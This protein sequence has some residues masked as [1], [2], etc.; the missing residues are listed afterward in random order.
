[1]T[2]TAEPVRSPRGYPIILRK[3]LQISALLIPTSGETNMSAAITALENAYT[4][5][6]LTANGIALYHT[7]GNTPTPHALPTANLLGFIRVIQK[8]FPNRDEVYANS[9]RFSVTVEADY[10]NDWP[11]LLVFS[12]TIQ[13]IGTGGP[14]FL[15]VDL[16]QGLPDEQITATNT[17]CRATQS[18]IAVQTSS[19]LIPGPQG[20][21][22]TWPWWPLNIQEK[23]TNITY[24]GP[25]RRDRY[26]TNYTSRWSYH[27]LSNEP[28]FRP[29]IHPNVAPH[30]V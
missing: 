7:T 22:R 16:V 20:D 5:T 4:D 9:R 28:F 1:V 26:L 17:Q 11:A 14:N 30:R 12:E 3:R 2:Y 21:A 27:F 10:K 23:L 13:L 8:S 29:N 25:E 6:N 19:F 18:G 15:M 24:S